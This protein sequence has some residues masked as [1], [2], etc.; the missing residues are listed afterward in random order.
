MTIGDGKMIRSEEY[1]KTDDGNCSGEVAVTERFEISFRDNGT[2]QMVNF[3]SDN[4]S[5]SKVELIFDKVFFSFND[6][7]YING[8]IP[9]NETTLC[10]ES[11]WTGVERDVTGCRMKNKTA[12]NGE[13]LKTIVHVTDNNTLLLEGSFD[14]YP[15]SFGCSRSVPEST[16]N[17]IYPECSS[18][19]S[20]SSS[21]DDSGPGIVWNMNDDLASENNLNDNGSFV[22]RLKS[23]PNNDVTVNLK[24]VNVLD[25]NGKDSVDTEITFDQ[26]SVIFHKS[27]V[28]G[29]SNWDQDQT[30]TFWA[31]DDDVDEDL[32]GP[33]NQSFKVFVDNVSVVDSVNDSDFL[34]DHSSHRSFSVDNLTARVVDDDTA[35]LVMFWKD[36]DNSTSEAGGNAFMKVKLGSRP[37]LEDDTSIKIRV[38]ISDQTEAYFKEADNLI[39]VAVGAKN[40]GEITTLDSGFTTGPLGFYKDFNFQVLAWD[41]GSQAMEVVGLDDFQNDGDVIN[42]LTASIF[43][44]TDPV[45]GSSTFDSG[46][47]LTFINVD[48]DSETTCEQTSY[49]ISLLMDGSTSMSLLCS[50]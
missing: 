1:I 18:S 5:V 47:N 24:V 43:S 40:L 37:F 36:N 10:G 49:N 28:F 45:Y 30:V 23:Q 35:S 44:S 16:G 12:F 14:D 34:F 48:N 15:T 25:P 21:S 17:Y 7:S 32:Q 20:S 50:E 8:L 19:S 46:D 22:V 4:I 11:Y 27:L 42:F 39:L 41:N 26:S 31:I 38:V 9:D 33:D 2:K 3:N 6:L 13:I 29:P